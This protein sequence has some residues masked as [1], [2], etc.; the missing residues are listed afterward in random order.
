MLK[1]GKNRSFILLRAMLQIIQDKFLKTSV[2][3]SQTHPGSVVSN[4]IFKGICAG[5]KAVSK[6]ISTG[7]WNNGT[8]LGDYSS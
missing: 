2:I 3:L 5:L 7:A 1:L 8:L 6:G 4:C